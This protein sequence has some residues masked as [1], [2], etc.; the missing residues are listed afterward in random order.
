MSAGSDSAESALIAGLEAAVA[1]STVAALRLHT[2]E[3]TRGEIVAFLGCS[4]QV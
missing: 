3:G 1:K 2:I 4:L